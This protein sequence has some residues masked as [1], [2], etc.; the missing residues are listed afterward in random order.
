MTRVFIC[1]PTYYLQGGVERILESLAS[2]LPVQG[3]EVIFGLVRGARFHD[4]RRGTAGLYFA[5]VVA[6]PHR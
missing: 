5:S 6:V 2:R 3:F 4:P 1:A